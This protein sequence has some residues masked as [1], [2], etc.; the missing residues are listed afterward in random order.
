MWFFCENYSFSKIVLQVSEK[1][2]LAGSSRGQCPYKVCHVL[3]GLFLVHV[4][5][6]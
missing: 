1:R 6:C 5:I 3:G 4:H 2:G